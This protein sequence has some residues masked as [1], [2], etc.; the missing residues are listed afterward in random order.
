MPGFSKCDDQAQ[1]YFD[2]FPYF[3]LQVLH[4]LAICFSVFDLT[5]GAFTD[6]PVDIDDKDLIRQVYLALMHIIQHSLR[7]LSPNLIIPAMPKQADR[8]DNI[9]FKRKPLLH[10]KILFLEP[11][12]AAEGDDFVGADHG[13]CIRGLGANISIG[14]E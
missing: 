1:P 5:A 12:A 8:D 14:M 13:G 3:L 2:F 11:G 10:L 9:T 4:D 6:I 7:P